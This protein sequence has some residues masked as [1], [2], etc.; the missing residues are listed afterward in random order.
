[1]AS[2]EPHRG[3]IWLVSLGAARAG[4]PGKSRPA[5]VVSIDEISAGV[6]DELLVVVPLSSSRAR[7]ELRPDVSPDEGVDSPS[8]AICRGVRAVARSRLMRP[9]GKARPETLREVQLALAMIL[10]IEDPRATPPRR[11]DR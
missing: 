3:E 6:E 1:M 11:R 2:T 5:I 9:I 7:S 4:E 10:G 8:A